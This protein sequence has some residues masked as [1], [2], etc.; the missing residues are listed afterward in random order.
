MIRNNRIGCVHLSFSRTYVHLLQF[1][2]V[3]SFP[4]VHS[5]TRDQGSL[6]SQLLQL[7]KAVSNHRSAWPFHEPVDTTVVVDYL[8]HIKEPVDLQLISKRID[9]GTYISKAAFKTDL[10]KMCKNCMHYNTPDTNYYKYVCGHVVIAAVPVPF[11]SN[12]SFDC[13]ELLWISANLF[14]LESTS[15]S[16]SSHC[17]QMCLYMCVCAHFETQLCCTEVALCYVARPFQFLKTQPHGG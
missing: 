13:P 3:V 1:C 10:D 17:T 15:E 14:S 6:K 8:D 5:R 16:K 9:N 2:H 7:L 11:D 12:A 4:S